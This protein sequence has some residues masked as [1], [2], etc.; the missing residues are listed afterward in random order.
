MFHLRAVR[1]GK[2]IVV[3]GRASPHSGLSQMPP[4]TGRGNLPGNPTVDAALAPSEPTN[5][6]LPASM[7]GSMVDEE[8]ENSLNPNLSSGVPLETTCHGISDGIPASV[9]KKKPQVNQSLGVV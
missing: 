2:E 4:G 7:N 9:K 1:M 3:M 5:A 8:T 6:A